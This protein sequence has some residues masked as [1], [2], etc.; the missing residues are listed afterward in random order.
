MNKTDLV[1]AV[2]KAGFSKKDADAAVTA[3]FDSITDALKGGDKVQ[4]VGFGTFAV[5]SR[6][7]KE[8]LNPRTKEKISI[9]ASKVPGFKAGKAL[10]DAV[11]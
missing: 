9:P 2:A 5:R 10:K 8:G 3:V 4:L 1:N 11:K 6:A 7:A